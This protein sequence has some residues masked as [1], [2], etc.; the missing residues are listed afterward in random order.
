[1]SLKPEPGIPF[2]SHYFSDPTDSA[3]EEAARHGVELGTA[4]AGLQAF[5]RASA[6]G[7]GSEDMSTVIE[8]LRNSRK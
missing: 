4:A 2:P 1:M 5:Q 8:P 3:I 7:H 6:E